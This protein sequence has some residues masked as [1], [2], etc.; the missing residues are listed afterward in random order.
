MEGRERNGS[1]N[2]QD[3]FITLSNISTGLELF[4]WESEEG[5]GDTDTLELACV[6]TADTDDEPGDGTKTAWSS[7]SAGLLTDYST[8]EKRIF[9]S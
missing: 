3:G 7:L 5:K 4:K 8:F 9:N 2:N 6:L 1:T